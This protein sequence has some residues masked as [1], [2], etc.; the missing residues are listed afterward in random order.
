METGCFLSLMVMKA[1]VHTVI[2][3]LSVFA[4]AFAFHS[5]TGQ[6]PNRDKVP[7][8]ATSATDGEVKVHGGKFFHRNRSFAKKLGGQAGSTEREG[9]AYRKQK[10]AGGLGREAKVFKSH[11]HFARKEKATGGKK[12]RGKKP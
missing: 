8:A 11:N 2:L 6:D 7:Q 1:K 5:A 9:K 10:K 3:S 4:L 12:T